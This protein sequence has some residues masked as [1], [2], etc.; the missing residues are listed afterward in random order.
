M[1]SESTHMAVINSL[2][3]ELAN[4]DEPATKA[5]IARMVAAQIALTEALSRTY[6]FAV[7]ATPQA[8]FTA[9]RQAAADAIGQA[10]DLL[11]QTTTGLEQMDDER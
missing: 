9:E 3:T 10:L 5:D 11:A 6:A 4:P 8:V 7:R 1:S 2:L